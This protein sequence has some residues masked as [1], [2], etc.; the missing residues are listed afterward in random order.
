VE[1]MREVSPCLKGTIDPQ[2]HAH[3]SARLELQLENALLWREVCINYF[4]QFVSA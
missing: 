2:R 4:S 1:E 3:I